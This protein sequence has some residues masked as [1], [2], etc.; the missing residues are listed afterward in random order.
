MGIV[1]AVCREI[2][3]VEEIDSIIGVDPRHKVTC[4]HGLQFGGE[5][6][7]RNAGAGKQVNTISE[8]K[9]NE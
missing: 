7:T 9:A 4:A 8:E 1:S 5:E 2:G 6:F 3:L